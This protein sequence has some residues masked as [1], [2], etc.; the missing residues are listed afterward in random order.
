MGNKINPIGLRVAVTKDWRSRW[1]ADKRAFGDMLH[2]DL[3]I[4]K[5]IR[6]DVKDAAVSDIRIERYAERARV[7]ISTARPGL[8]IGRQGED[9]DR[10]RAKLAEKT[11][12]E[13]FVEVD[14]IKKADLDAQLVAEN[15]TMHLE[16]RMS[17]RRVLKRAIQSTMEMGAEGVKILA[18]GRLGGSELSRVESY[19]EGK[20]PLHTLRANID[21][22]FAEAHTLAGDIGIKV[23][24]CKKD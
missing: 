14:E 24:I 23:W 7:T 10:L 2:E 19:K 8:V 5:I 12:K 6:E 1:Y 22:G 9:I 16:R 21:Y 13:I 3:L 18:S 4:R 17:F 11:G 20:T 15:I